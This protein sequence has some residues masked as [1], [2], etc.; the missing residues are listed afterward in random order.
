M[1]R[2]QLKAGDEEG[3]IMAWF[4]DIVESEALY[5]VQIEV[6]LLRARKRGEININC[7]AY[8]T[9]RK[10]SDEP[11]AISNTPYP[12]AAATTL[13]AALYRSAVRI[14]GEISNKRRDE[15]R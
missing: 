2:R 8:K 4:D 10:P 5:G 13:Y 11:Y 14:G 7:I 12:S 9:P 6:V 15:G 1:S 3:F